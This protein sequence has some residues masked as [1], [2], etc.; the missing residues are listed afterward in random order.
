MSV[1]FR[2]ISLLTGLWGQYWGQYIEH[3]WGVAGLRCAFFL[4]RMYKLT[5]AFVNFLVFFLEIHYLFEY[6]IQLQRANNFT[7][8]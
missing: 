2:R 7:T 4:Q 1:L 6:Y 8:Y 3:F 5:S